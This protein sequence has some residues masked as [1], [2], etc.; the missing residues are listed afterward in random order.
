MKKILER[1]QFMNSEFSRKISCVQ[2]GF[3]FA[4]AVSYFA[5]RKTGCKLFYDLSDKFIAYST[6]CFAAG[7][8][9][10]VVNFTAN[11]EVL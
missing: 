7:V 4:D 1:T 3:S 10:D 11:K 6:A 2:L 8:V 9:S 5:G